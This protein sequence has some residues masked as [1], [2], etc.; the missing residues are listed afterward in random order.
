VSRIDAE[1][2]SEELQSRSGDR[3]AI[4]LL[5]AARK[6][7]RARSTYRQLSELDDSQL[8]DIGLTRSE[9]RS[10]AIGNGGR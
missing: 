10:V 3:W 5:K 4:K 8:K 2:L 9:I 1:T 6:W 7:Q